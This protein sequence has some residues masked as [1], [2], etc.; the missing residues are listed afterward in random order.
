MGDGSVVRDYL[1]VDD[2]AA[3]FRAALNYVGDKSI[4]NIGSGYGTSLN[5]LIIEIE[6]LLNIRLNRE[7]ATA[8]SFDVPY[9][10]LCIVKS[11]DELGWTP[12]TAIEAGLSK[13]I[14]WLKNNKILV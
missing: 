8:R 10:T 9:N 4:F 3:A 13:T 7:Y 14:E 12:T 1:Y 5:Q 11:K 2:V 6:K